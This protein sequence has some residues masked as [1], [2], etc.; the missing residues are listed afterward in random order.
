M[1]ASD[2][3][4]FVVPPILVLA[5]GAI[6]I[7]FAPV[8]PKMLGSA[9]GPTATGFW[10]TFIGTGLLF[11]WVIAARKSFRLPRVI[12]GWSALAG[13]IFF[14]DLWF[15]HRSI[16]YC[17]AGLATILANTQVFGTALLS[18]IVFK[19]RLSIK[20]FASA[21]AAIVGIVLL[22]GIGSDFEFTR[23]YLSGVGLGLLTGMV[24]AS[25][26]IVMKLARQTGEQ[27]DSRVLMAWTSFFSA[28]FLFIAAGWEEA[29]FMPP[30][31]HSLFILFVLALV[32][33]TLGWWL[34]TVSLP[35]L[36]ASRSGL[37]LLLQP[38]LATVWGW[39]FFRE[40]LT[41]V[42][43]IGAGVTFAAIYYG[44]TRRKI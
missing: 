34:I 18:Y 24:Y 9:M 39:L 28:F 10:R 2:K 29:P 38:I 23:L 26:I 7:S 15:W 36:D 17:G 31:L 30:D 11:A 40:N 8:F 42:Q 16:L 5:F 13:F 3:K 27:P 37:M 20:F 41:T 1:S 35:E 32:A 12:F 43:L 4:P 22:I 33:Q 21:I 14:L 6:C 44:S 25:Y 19:E